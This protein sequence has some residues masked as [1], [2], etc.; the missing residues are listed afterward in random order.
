[1][2]LGTSTPRSDDAQSNGKQGDICW[3]GFR[4][5]FPELTDIHFLG[6]L[7]LKTVVIRHYSENREDVGKVESDP[8]DDGRSPIPGTKNEFPVFM[9]LILRTTSMKGNS[10]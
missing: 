9:L 1:M 6:R 4:G 10:V 5:L 2:I 3:A 8:R 7:R